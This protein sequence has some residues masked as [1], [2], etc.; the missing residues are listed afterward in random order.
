MESSPLFGSIY[1]SV[2]LSNFGNFISIYIYIYVGYAR[3]KARTFPRSHI[4]DGFLINPVW[5]GQVFKLKA[6]F[7]LLKEGGGIGQ[8]GSGVELRYLGMEMYQCGRDSSSRLIILS[9]EEQKRKSESSK[10]KG[11]CRVTSN[12]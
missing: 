2:E 8:I 5:M 11:E 10:R 3:E 9:L 4:A 1:R 6:N 12:I 7:P